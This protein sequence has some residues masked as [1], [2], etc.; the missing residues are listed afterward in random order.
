MAVQFLLF[1]YFIKRHLKRI[2]FNKAEERLIKGV[3][4]ML[5][6]RLTSRTISSK[7]AEERQTRRR[8]RIVGK[9]S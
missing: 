5:H 4:Q 2:S 9:C 1:F 6:H 3:L 7:R 8:E